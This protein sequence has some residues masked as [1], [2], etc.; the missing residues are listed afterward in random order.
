VKKTPRSKLTAEEW[1]E[2]YPVGTRV[3]Y[4]PVWGERDGRESTTRTPAWTLGHGEPVV[5]IEGQAGGVALWA[6]EVIATPAPT[7]A[8]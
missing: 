4:R 3:F 2:R 8:S 5:S 1:N 6:L 7:V